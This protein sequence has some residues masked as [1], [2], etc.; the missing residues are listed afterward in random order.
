MMTTIHILET[1]ALGFLNN[2][3]YTLLFRG[4]L[5]VKKVLKYKKYK[6]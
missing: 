5:Y 3:H 1:S 4:K 2:L 6:N